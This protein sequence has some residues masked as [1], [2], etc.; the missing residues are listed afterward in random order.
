MK[1]R[2]YRV[3]AAV[4]ALIVLFGLVTGC[5]GNRQGSEPDPTPAPEETPRPTPP[6]PTPEP[7][8]EPV[9][10][11]E[12]DIN[13][14]VDNLFFHEAIA[15]PEIAFPNGVDQFNLDEYMNTVHEFNTILQ[16]LYDR[17]FVLVNL[18]DVWEEFIN[19][20]GQRR[21]RRISPFM[22][23][24]GKRPIVLSFDDLT[25]HLEPAN[26]FMH[27]YIIGPDGDVWAEGIDPSGNPI[28]TQDLAAITIL[29]KFVKENPGFSHNGAKGLIAQ[30]G[31]HGILGY[32]TQ[33]NR[34]D[35]SDEFRLNRRMEIARARPVIDRLTETGWYWGS[36]SWGHIRF[37]S[38]SLE[39]IQQDAQRWNDEVGS[40]IGDTVIMV[41]AHGSRLDGN[42][43]WR[44]TAG[45]ALRYY[46]DELGFRMF[47][48]VGF[49][50]F[51]RARRDVSAVMMD[52]MNV[53]GIALRGVQ[54][55]V[56]ERDN[57]LLWDYTKFYNV[58]EVFDPLRPT[59]GSR[60]REIRWE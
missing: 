12:Y 26:A 45:P 2:A 24:E 3:S 5:F 58:R 37:D 6:P 19:D 48:S 59:E 56:R 33:T 36:H 14:P 47:L 18:H 29:D 22:L 20:S 16:S 41:Y 42:D 9:V 21:M 38:S 17:N 57:V 35:D 52:R 55:Q 60:V 43:V 10:L 49:E 51:S 1:M 7:T 8:P 40:L 25:F 13:L 15:Y 50:P 44:E 23:P 54:R 28:I 39:R 53:D 11:V 32:S 34:N 27:R 31:L 30:T 4:I 46:I